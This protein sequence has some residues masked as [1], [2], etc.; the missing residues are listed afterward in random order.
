MA[1]MLMPPLASRQY[2]LK[3]GALLAGQP[4]GGFLQ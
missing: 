3:V 4:P 1:D 2:Q